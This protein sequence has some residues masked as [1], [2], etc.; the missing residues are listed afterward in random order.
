M[1]SEKDKTVKLLFGINFAVAAFCLSN[2]ADISSKH[3]H[4]IM[5]RQLKVPYLAKLENAIQPGQS[6]IAR[7]LVTGDRFDINFQQ[8]VHEHNGIALHVSCRQHEKVFV[9]NTFDEGCWKKETRFKSPLKV[10][11]PFDLRIRAHDDRFEMFANHKH[12][13]DYKHMQPLT[14]INHLLIT[15][16]CE[17]HSVLWEG[18]YYPKPYEC[19]MDGFKPGRRLF[20][21]GVPADGAKKFNINLCSGPDIAFHFNPRFNE[22]KV[23]R[24]AMVNGSWGNEERNGDFPFDKKKNFDI[25]FVC[26]AQA[27]QV[28]VNNMEFTNFVHRV[29]PEKIDSLKIEG[30][31]EL[32]LIHL[33]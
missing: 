33:E 31:L 28:Y 22:K 13:G 12:V 2:F 1:I 20:V 26:E 27:I 32:Q 16:T 6:L 30:D 18:N 25:L 4:K 23:V 19:R 5:E 24:N 15:G 10:G 7:G 14:S 29:A 9:L 11:E 8:G 17:L 21:S 3:I